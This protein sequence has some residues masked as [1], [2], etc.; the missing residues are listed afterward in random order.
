MQFSFHLISA[1]FPTAPART[2]RAGSA[3]WE[4]RALR[5]GKEGRL[6][7]G[8]VAQAGRGWAKALSCALPN[9]GF[10]TE[11]LR[12]EGTKGPLPLP[13]ISQDMGSLGPSL[14]FSE[15]CPEEGTLQPR[16]LPSPSGKGPVAGE[17][18]G[19]WDCAQSC[20]WSPEIT[21]GQGRVYPG[22]EAPNG[23]GTGSGLGVRAVS[24]GLGLRQ[25]Q[26]RTGWSF[27]SCL[28]LGKFR[29]LGCACYIKW[30]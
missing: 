1:G 28:A 3:K 21:G 9:Y 7:P 17:V 20:P 6:P 29:K 13:W 25:T 14:S 8:K 2:L 4:A 16:T 23:W 19:R 5:G 24:T 22:E 18:Q 15:L 30:K 10:R 26:S 11:Q 12:W 27:M